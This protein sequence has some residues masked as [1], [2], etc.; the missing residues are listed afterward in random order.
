MRVR[1]LFISHPLHA[2]VKRCRVWHMGTNCRVWSKRSISKSSLTSCVYSDGLIDGIRRF[3]WAGESGHYSAF[4]KG[5]S[6][7]G[8]R[9]SN[10]RGKED[11]SKIFIIFCYYLV[12]DD[13]RFECFYM[14]ELFHALTFSRE[15]LFEQI[16]WASL[17][18]VHSLLILLF[19]EIMGVSRVGR[20]MNQTTEKRDGGGR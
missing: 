5:G 7:G 13:N 18:V 17:H 9:W 10:E 6:F 11:A 20:R 16:Y 12:D 1:L 2:A 3:G 19:G 8:E 4:A 15:Y 14:Y